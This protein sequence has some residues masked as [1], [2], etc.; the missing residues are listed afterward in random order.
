MFDIPR[1]AERALDSLVAGCHLCLML[2]EGWT[3]Q[4][5]IVV[6]A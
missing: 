4:A 2:E 1:I 3:E 5:V 6:C